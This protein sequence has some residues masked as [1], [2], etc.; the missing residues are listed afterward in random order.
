MSVR[1][2]SG[3]APVGVVTVPGV[4]EVVN[5]EAVVVLFDD[6]AAAGSTEVLVEVPVPCGCIL[7]S[8]IGAAF[9]VKDVVTTDAD[10]DVMLWDGGDVDD[11]GVVEGC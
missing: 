1:V 6:E 7:D 8:E 11:D 10:D 2:A 4:V 5:D 3:P 9:V